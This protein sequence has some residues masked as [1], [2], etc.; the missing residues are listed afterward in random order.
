V[1]AVA[2]AVL[3]QF[4]LGDG[5]LYP[6]EV[7]KSDATT[8]FEG[9]WHTWIF[10]NQKETANFEASSG[11]REFSSMPDDPWRKLPFKPANGDLAVSHK[12]LDG[13]DV[14]VEKNLFQ[15][16]FVSA[17]LGNALKSAGLARAFRLAK[18]RVV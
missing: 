2:A 18:A 13:A 14:W 9:E 4:D 11:L 5:A 6:V 15:S 7:R 8:S 17:A 3:R 1:N 12:A 16:V 10:G